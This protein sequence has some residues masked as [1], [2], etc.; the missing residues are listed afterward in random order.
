MK[1]RELRTALNSADPDAEVLATDG[2]GEFFVITESELCHLVRVTWSDDSEGWWPP[3]L[4]TAED[5]AAA[6]SETEH[7]VM[8]LL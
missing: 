6:K 1:V 2:Q 7:Y 3:E 4:L 5:H 8:V